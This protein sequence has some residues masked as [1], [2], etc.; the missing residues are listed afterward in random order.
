MDKY[1]HRYKNVSSIIV[2]KKL[3]TRLPMK[4]GERPTVSIYIGVIILFLRYGIIT[5]NS[6]STHSLW[7]QV[8]VQIHIQN[9][10][11]FFFLEYV[12]KFIEIDVIIVLDF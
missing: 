1:E 4:R 6:T 9:K 12:M 8:L 3:L 2:V 5:P 11:H 7:F 10:K